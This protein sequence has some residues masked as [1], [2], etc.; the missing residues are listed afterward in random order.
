[1]RMEGHKELGGEPVR[2]ADPADH[3]NIPDHM[4]SSS[5][6]KAGG[7]KKEGGDIWNNGIYLPR[8]L[9]HLEPCSPGD[10]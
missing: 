10:G 8:S 9:L 1:M 2:T 5:A 6:Y 4:A 7:K 3:R